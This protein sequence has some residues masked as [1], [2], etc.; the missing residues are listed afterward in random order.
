MGSCE[1]ENKTSFSR[2]DFF[3]LLIVEIL[4]HL[5]THIDT[6]IHTHTHTHTYGRTPLDKRSAPRSSLYLHNTQN[7]TRDKHPCPGRIPTSKPSNRVA[8]D[9]RLR[10]RG[11]WDRLKMEL[12][13]P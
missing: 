5:V 7:L 2:T 8:A 12:L 4:L 3:Y 6:H 10:Q 13:L 1:H 9:M 11:H